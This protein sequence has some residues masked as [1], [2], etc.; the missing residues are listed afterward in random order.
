MQI[1]TAGSTSNKTAVQSNYSVYLCSWVASPVI[2]QQVKMM[3]YVMVTIVRERFIPWYPHELTAFQRAILGYELPLSVGWISKT[4]HL[5]GLSLQPATLLMPPLVLTVVKLLYLLYLWKIQDQVACISHWNAG[6]FLGNW[7][8]SLCSF[9]QRVWDLSCLTCSQTPLNIKGTWP[10]SVESVSLLDGN[11]NFVFILSCL[12]ILV[13]LPAS[14][15]ITTCQ[16]GKKTTL[17]CEDF[18]C[19]VNS[20]LVCVVSQ[21]IISCW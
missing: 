15:L 7:K 19:F 3:L 4:T 13:R 18:F 6:S 8:N 9:C 11:L 2:P 10:E 5:H 16:K 21:T 14:A 12:R 20:E 1:W 17:D